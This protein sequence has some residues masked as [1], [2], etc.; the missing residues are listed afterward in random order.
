MKRIVMSA[1]ATA[2]LL[3]AELFAGLKPLE[4][5]NPPIHHLAVYHRS[6]RPDALHFPAREGA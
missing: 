5:G 2:A 3:C 1:L 4:H 6:R